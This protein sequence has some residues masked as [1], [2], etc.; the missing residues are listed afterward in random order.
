VSTAGGNRGKVVKREMEEGK[1]AKSH[2]KNVKE[3]VGESSGLKNGEV[4]KKTSKVASGKDSSGRDTVS[5]GLPP[6]VLSHKV[7]RSKK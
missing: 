5:D 6:L 7:S 1:L 3:S 4:I 2:A